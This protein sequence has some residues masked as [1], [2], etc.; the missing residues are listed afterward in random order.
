MLFLRQLAPLALLTLADAVAVRQSG[1]NCTRPSRPGT[2]SGTTSASTSG[3]DTLLAAADGNLASSYD[4]VIVGGGA[5]GLTVANRLSEDSGGYRT[6]G[7]P[8]WLWPGL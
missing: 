6:P 3:T 4:Y 5:A 2:T 7:A 8:P 1:A